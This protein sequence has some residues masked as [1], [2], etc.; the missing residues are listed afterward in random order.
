SDMASLREQLESLEAGP[1]ALVITDG[2]FS[3]EGDLASLREI[4]GLVRAHESTFVVD[5]SHGTGV[6]GEPGRGVAEH[7]G[8]LGEVDVITSTLGKAL[9]GAGGRGGAPER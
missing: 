8:L 2:V 7:Y 5:D 9:R 3:M 6:V 4:V 1:R